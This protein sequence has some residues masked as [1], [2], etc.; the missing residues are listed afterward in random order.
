MKKFK[1]LLVSSLIIT[2]L[3]L[4]PFVSYAKN[5]DKYRNK[6]NKSARAAINTKVKP[7]ISG[8][9]APTVLKVGE[10]GTWTVNASDPQNGSLSYAVNWG[11][12]K[13]SLFSK[14]AQPEIFVQSS[15]FTHAYASAGKYKVMFRV[16]N[17]AGLDTTSSVTVHVTGSQA[18]APIISNVTATSTKWHQATIHWTT[19]VRASSLVWYSK[20][21]PV[22]TTV[23]PRVYRTAKVFDH[24]INLNKLQPNTTYYV[25]VGSGNG[26]RTLGTEISFTTPAKDAIA[27][28]PVITSLSGPTTIA[29]G[30]TETVTINAYDPQNES[31]SYS[32]DWGDSA[33]V[34]SISR[35]SNPVF[36]QTAT[37]EHVYSTPGTYTATFTAKNSSGKSTSSSMK[38]TVTATT[39]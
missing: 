31:I 33:S 17:S 18:N 13:D 34:I 37:F 39:L 14:M 23:R 22:N 15:T 27:S 19:D 1:P 28:T 3:V 11:D 2:A 24:K 36:V 35:S 25:V 6:E 29:V 20:T 38:I 8:I 26:V 30:Q 12:A 32:A 5:D 16:S 21:S 7:S 4:A 10:M 9:T